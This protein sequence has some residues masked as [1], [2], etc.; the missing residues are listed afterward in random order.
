MDYNRIVEEIT[1][2]GK[3]MYICGA[4][5]HRVED[6]VQR[7]LLSYGAQSCDVFA[8]TSQITVSARFENRTYTVMKRIGKTDPDFTK[9]ALYNSLSRRL[10]SEHLPIEEVEK[11]HAKIL[12]SVTLPWYVSLTAYMLCC[13]SFAVFFGGDAIDG[14]SSAVLGILMFAANRYLK[15]HINEFIYIFVITFLIGCLGIFFVSFGFGHNLDKVLIGTVM[16][17]IPGMFIT[18]SARDIFLG[19]TISGILKLFESLLLVVLIS[20]GYVLA[21]YLF[22][23]VMY[24]S[25][26]ST[27]PWYVTYLSCLLGSLSFALLFKANLRMIV[28]SAVGSCIAAAFYVLFSLTYPLS[29]FLWSSLLALFAGIYGEILARFAKTPAIS[30]L[31]I[32]LLPFYPGGSIY[33]TFTYLEEQQNELFLANFK[34]AG[35]TILGIASGVIVSTVLVHYVAVFVQNVKKNRSVKK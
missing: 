8:I 22:P 15:P 26:A 9:I 3:E 34:V 16:L 4:E 10:C 7:M 29:T 11:E 5:V 35:F 27:N 1:R 23:S 30:I 14:L 18:N 13:F 32:V 6:T 33:Y 28:A 24:S 20:L 2:I 19:D 12:A 21:I 31:S 17:V 25:T